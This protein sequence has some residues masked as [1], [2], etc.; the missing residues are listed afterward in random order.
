[1]I[2]APS[3]VLADLGDTLSNFQF[4][5]AGQ[6]EYTSNVFLSAHD[7]KS[8]FITTVT[9]GLRFSTLPRSE[10]TGQFEP[11]ATSAKTRYGLDLDYSMPLV[12]YAK[13]S[14]DNYVGLAG[15]LNAWYAFDPK[16]IFRVR[17]YSVRSEEPRERE[18]VPGAL[19]DQYL[20]G[21]DRGRAIYFRNVFEPSLAYQ[22][23]KDSLFGLNYRSNIYRNQNSLFGNSRE[24]FVNPK[25][26]YWFDIRNGVSFE[27]GLTLGQFD[28]SPDLTGHAGTGRY[29]YRF[30][31]RTSIF[32]EYT[33]LRRDFEQP[34]P[35][36]DV[37]RPSIGISH[38]FSP[39]LTG[40][41][42][43]GYFWQIPSI[44]STQGGV[45]YDASLT[46]RARRTTYSVLFQGGYNEDYFTAQNLGFSKYHR[47]VGIIRH[48]PMQRMT[49]GISGSLERA[50][51]STGEID[52]LWEI[53]GSASYQVLRW[54]AFSVEVSHREDHSNE[55]IRDYDETRGLFRIMASY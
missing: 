15:T 8:D 50:K 14:N 54:L 41:A 38:D 55:D 3:A 33:F 11:A 20:L 13:G 25:F 35:D 28:R 44:G 2:A 22:F 32:G 1:M 4:S 9:P 26:N 27:Y 7:K 37:H 10:R 31:P 34:S 45:Y 53:R 36:Y 21:T 52:R 46:E 5:I 23:A 30:G 24:D 51:L 49:V 48:Q 29:T 40:R 42:Q 43:V 17:N 39:T 6:E 16:W 12:Y 47:V 19:P 18:Y